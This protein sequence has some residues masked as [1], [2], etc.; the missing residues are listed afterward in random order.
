MAAELLLLLAPGAM[1]CGQGLHRFL[2]TLF[3]RVQGLA[4]V[5]QPFKGQLAFPL[6]VE[7]LVPRATGLLQSSIGGL[8]ILLQLLP[9]RGVVVAAAALFG[10][11]Q[12]MQFL[13]QRGQFL[14]DPV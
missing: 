10:G 3:F 7:Q 9:G 5:P 11:F 2:Q 13:L 1:C 8:Q 14:S 4:L 12:L 6:G